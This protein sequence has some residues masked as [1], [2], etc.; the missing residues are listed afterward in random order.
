M[1]FGSSEALQRA[2]FAALTAD[3]PLAALVGGV[4]DA[5]PR[6]GPPETY[7]ALGPERVSRT[8]HRG[9]VVAVHDFQVSVVTAAEGYA[10]AKRAAARVEAVLEAG[11]ALDAGRLL[12]IALRGARARRDR[13]DGTRRVDLTFRARIEN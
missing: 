6:A 2:C 13:R 1:S 8:A 5:A 10:G 12:G 7:V 3:G 4:F 11:V 9:G